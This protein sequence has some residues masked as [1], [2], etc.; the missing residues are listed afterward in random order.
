MEESWDA[1]LSLTDPWEMQEVPARKLPGWQGSS[2][3][4]PV[5]S[6]IAAKSAD[7]RRLVLVSSSKPRA[8][9]KSA[10]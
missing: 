10:A 7:Q 1:P 5:R 8:P 9:S 2:P 3:H 4:A 6:K